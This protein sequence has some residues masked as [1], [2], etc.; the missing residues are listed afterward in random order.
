M[1]ANIPSG[2][3]LKAVKVNG[4]DITDNGIEIKSAEAIT[5]VEVVLTS[6]ITEVK[7]AVKARQRSGAATTPS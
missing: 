1:S 7:G 4:T 2:W 5:G 6:K 3:V